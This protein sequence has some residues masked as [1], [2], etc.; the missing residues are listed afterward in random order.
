MDP[1]SRT[2]ILRFAD[3]IEAP[4]AT[5]L[6]AR[7]LF[8]GRPHDLGICGT[9]AHEVAQTTFAAADCVIVFG[10]GLNR[11]TTVDGSLVDG[12]SL[13]QVDDDPE[14]LGR[15]VVPDAGVLGDAATCA[16]AFYA[17]LEEAEVPPTGF[18]SPELASLLARPPA[19]PP[20]RSTEESV[21]I[22][23]AVRLVDAAVDGARTVVTDS[24]RFVHSAW[25]V[26][27]VEDPRHFAHTANFG[28]IGLGMGTAIGA[29]V[30][31][32]GHPTLLVTGDGGFMLGGLNEFSTA[33]RHGLD[34]IVL[35]LNDGSYGA[36]H[37]Q[38]VRRE[39]DPGMSLFTWP[40]LGPVADALGGQGFTVRNLPEL[41]AALAQ[42]PRRD[43]P[44]LLDVHLDPNLVPSIH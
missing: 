27:G 36:E 4:V 26:L 30:G 37:I 5:T 6:K 32:P 33:V 34:L 42:L 14:A 7:D 11:F 41:E 43:G 21:D 23:T 13:V 17:L 10:A 9:V 16:D 3:R 1:R 44:V 29:C 18:A 28:S 39:L 40:D 22:H 8:R 15:F 2:A 19:V 24:G 35:V 38:F 12:R 31:R 20:D 25:P